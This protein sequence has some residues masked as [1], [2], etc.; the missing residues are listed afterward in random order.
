MPT[1]EIVLTNDPRFLR[2]ML[3]FA[4][5]QLFGAAAVS[6]A[7]ASP[8]LGNLLA[9]K[10][11]SWLVVT[12]D[13]YTCIPELISRVTRLFPALNIMGLSADGQVVRIRWANGNEERRDNPRFNELAQV[14]LR[15]EPA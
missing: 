13:S 8:T 6:Q 1:H 5:A 15:F 10:H 2:E 3:N 11:P 12:L 7:Q 14:L 9:E 4:L